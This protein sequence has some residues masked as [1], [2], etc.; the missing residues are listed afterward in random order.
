MKSKGWSI[1]K[2]WWAI[3]EFIDGTARGLSNAEIVTWILLWRD[4]KKNG[5]AK[6]SISYLAERSG[7]SKRRIQQSLELLIENGLVKRVKRGGMAKGKQWLSLW[8][9]W[10]F[11]GEA[12]CALPCKGTYRDD[13][14]TDE[15]L[16]AEWDRVMQK[17]AAG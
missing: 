12:E 5:L 2:R 6:T 17:R 8:K 14:S 9:V 13:D 1:K 16:G 10:P 7:M 11:M 4:T 3:T 15:E